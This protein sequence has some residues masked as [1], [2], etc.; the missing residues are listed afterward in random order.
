VDAK[1]KARI[2]DEGYDPAYGA[3]PIKR[4]IQRIL[5]DPLA[6]AFLEG[7]FGDG[8]RIQATIGEAGDMVFHTVP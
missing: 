6:M 3:R 8:D 2:A 1:V 4:A 7:E 5:A